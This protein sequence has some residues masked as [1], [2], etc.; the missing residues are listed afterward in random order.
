MALLILNS[1]KSGKE[2][3]DNTLALNG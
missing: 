1:G 3:G 2:M